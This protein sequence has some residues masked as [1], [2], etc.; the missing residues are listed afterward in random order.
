M[1]LRTE[2]TAGRLN[3]R[4]QQQSQTRDHRLALHECAKRSDQKGRTT[5]QKRLYA[6]A[7]LPAVSKAESKFPQRRHAK[8]ITT[9]EREICVAVVDDEEDMRL[10]LR[11]A[12]T[13]A[14]GF[15]CVGCFANASEA[16]AAIPTLRPDIV[17]MDIG[18]PDVN[19]IE[20]TRLLKEINPE[21]KIIM[22]S[23]RHNDESIHESLNAGADGYLTKPVVI[24][25]FLATLSFAVG[26][27]NEINSVLTVR[28]NQI[29]QL[30]AQGLLYKEIADKLAISYSSVH[31][32]QHNIFVKL[33]VSNRIEAIA[34]WRKLGGHS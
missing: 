32:Y 17:L 21:L 26:N 28:E 7:E 25:Q 34:K 5:P 27:R 1:R 2:P 6:A 18:M 33:H 15:R 10:L 31:K 19:G 8:E 13:D 22:L 23:G 12:L 9:S 3:I 24:K 20:C 16:L 29:M 4:F 14:V 30:F 11:D